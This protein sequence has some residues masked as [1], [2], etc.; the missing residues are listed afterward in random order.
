MLQREED[1]KNNYDGD[2][3]IDSIT[4]LIFGKKLIKNYQGM[5][6]K[7]TFYEFKLALSQHMKNEDSVICDFFR[8]RLLQSGQRQLTPVLKNGPEDTALTCDFLSL[9]K[10]SIPG[11]QDVKMLDCLIHCDERLNMTEICDKIREGKLKN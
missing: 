10:L 1:I 8:D 2:A 3:A 4:R 11:M 5:R 6:S 9:L 7:V